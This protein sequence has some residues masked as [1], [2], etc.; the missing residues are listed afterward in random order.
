MFYESN[1]KLKHKIV[2]YKPASRDSVH[3][4]IVFVVLKE[5]LESNSDGENVVKC[6]FFRL[7]ARGRLRGWRS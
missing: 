1:G 5:M 2:N 4:E 6:L 7:M 3:L